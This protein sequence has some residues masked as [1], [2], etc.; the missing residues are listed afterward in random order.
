VIARP[1][2]NPSELTRTVPIVFPVVGDP[3]GAGLVD[4]LARRV[5]TPPVSLRF[6]YGL[7]ARR[8]LFEQFQRFRVC[9]RG[10]IEPSRNRG[11][12]RAA[13]RTSG[14]PTV[15]RGH[16]AGGRG[17]AKGQLRHA[18]RGRQHLTATC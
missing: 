2:F 18:S 13:R 9:L 7:S 1:S 11:P 17:A 4:S 16:A 3:V 5:A 10:A 8:D 14:V 15:C 6:E 12:G